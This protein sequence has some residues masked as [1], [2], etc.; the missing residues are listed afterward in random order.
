MYCIKKKF[1]EGTRG[2]FAIQIEGGAFFI[3]YLQE[4]ENQKSHH[5]LE[6][7]NIVHA[8]IYSTNIGCL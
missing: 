6:K 2:D 5:P 7:V 1:K 4:N 8:Y 3:V